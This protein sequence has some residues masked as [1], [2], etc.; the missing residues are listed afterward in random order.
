MEVFNKIIFENEPANYSNKRDV[1]RVLKEAVKN[2][3]KKEVQD[4]H[5]KNV[6]D[7]LGKDRVFY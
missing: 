7:M 3:E 6:K 2:G 1:A 4:R 5:V